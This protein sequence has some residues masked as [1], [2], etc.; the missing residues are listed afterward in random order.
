M[1]KLPTVA[2]LTTS[3]FALTGCDQIPSFDP[4][5]RA[6]NAEACQSIAQAWDTISTGISG[7]DPVASLAGLATLPALI[8]EASTLANDKQLTEALAQ[9]K[10]TAEDALLTGQPDLVA[11]ASATVGIAGRCTILGTPVELPV[12]GQG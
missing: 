11:L 8:D 2:I 9:L 12:P 10:L 3:L 7:T 1:K 4:E 5:D 6:R